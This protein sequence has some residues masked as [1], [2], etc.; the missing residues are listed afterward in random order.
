MP[1]GISRR[2]FVAASAAAGAACLFPGLNTLGANDRV[3]VAI[4]GC[5]VKGDGHIDGFRQIEG[6]RVVAISDPDLKRMDEGAAKLQYAVARHR[7]FRH[8]LDDKNIDAVVIATPNHWHAPMT[9]MA[10]KAG[11]HVYVEKPVSHGIWEG[12]Q[13]VRVAHAHDRVVQAGTQHRSD[14]ALRELAADLRSGMYGKVLWI[15]CSRLVAREPI[16]KVTEPITIPD[17][18]DYNLWAGP[19]PMTPVMRASFHYDW[20]WQWSWGDGEVGNWG[21]HY[22]DDVLHFL[23]LDTVP[24]RVTAAGNRFAWDDNGQTP[25][26]HLTLFDLQGIPLVVDI[27]NLPDLQRPDG[28]RAGGDGGAVYLRMRHGNYIMCER[29]FI[30]MARGGGKSYDRDTGQEIKHYQGT[31][32]SGHDRN[33]IDAIRTGRRSDL[34]AEIEISHRSTILCH[35]A[36]ISYRLGTRA[37]IDEVRSACDRHADAI[38]TLAHMV[39]QVQGNGVDLSR[40][41][42]VLGPQLEFDAEAERFTGPHAKAANE[43]LRYEY[44]A[45]F[46]RE[47]DD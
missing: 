24:T 22:V 38:E 39:E 4:I 12:R 35:Q 42:F 21:V 17:H 34:N 32:G 26:M 31:G 28:Q 6:V 40:T 41:G 2:E 36:N 7:D 20:H 43:F 11:K 30:R 14:P 45:P 13:M 47:L 16:G 23:E 8:V 27:R 33:F 1:K 18:I 19:A 29:G 10:C 44:R 46:A 25:N 9:I 37:A 5:G 15:H 3:N